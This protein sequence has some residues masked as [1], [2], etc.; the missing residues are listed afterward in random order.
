MTYKIGIKSLDGSGSQKRGVSIAP[1]S[2]LSM[3]DLAEYCTFNVRNT[4]ESEEPPLSG[5]KNLSPSFNQDIYRLTATIE[6]EGWNFTLLNNLIS[7]KSG[8]SEKVPVFVSH[9]KVFSGSAKVILTARSESDPSKFATSS[10]EIKTK[11]EKR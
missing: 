5:D 4:G 7:I 3:K 10:F 9:Q 8:N 1:A 6:G 2:A 11:P